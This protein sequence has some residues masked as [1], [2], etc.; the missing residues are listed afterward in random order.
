MYHYKHIDH[1]TNVNGINLHFIEYKSAKPKLLL[2]HGLT[3]N[4]HAFDGLMSAGLHKSF[5]VFSVDFRGNGLSEHPLCYTV[6]DH[7]EDIVGLIN[8]LGDEKIVIAGHSYGGYIGFYLAANY[9]HLVD[10]LIILDAGRAMNPN[11]PEMLS[12]ALSRLDVTYKS[13]DDYLEKVKKAPYLDFW[14]D[15]M[16]SYYKADVKE[17]PDGEVKPRS[18]L[19]FIIE[20]SMGL[21]T[22]DWESQILAIQQP[23]ILVNA[24]DNYTMGEPLLPDVLAK[25]TVEMMKDAIYAAVDGN[26]QTMLYGTGARQTV[27]AIKDFLKQPIA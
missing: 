3:A 20:K 6:Q 18:V 5:N 12:S 19:A 2:M 24:M 23:S 22:T 4:A 14:E 8:H 11:A 21:A 27:D 9:P 1:Y 25:E 17:L 13:F 7:A 10:K 26:H 15:T 16:L